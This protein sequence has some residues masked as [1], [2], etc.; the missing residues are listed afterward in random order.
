MQNLEA[1]FLCKKRCK[2]FFTQVK[3]SLFEE[4]IKMENIFLMLQS[5][6]KRVSTQEMHF[7]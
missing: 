5:Y 3:Q 4:S 6:E 1:T 2:M 7:K